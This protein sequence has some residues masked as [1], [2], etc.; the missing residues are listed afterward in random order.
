MTAVC[1]VSTFGGCRLFGTTLNMDELPKVLKRVNVLDDSRPY[2]APYNTRHLETPNATRYQRLYWP[3]RATAVTT[4]FSPEEAP[5]ACEEPSCPWKFETADEMKDHYLRH[6]RPD[7]D[8][9]NA[10]AVALGR[11]RAARDKLPRHKCAHTIRGIFNKLAPAVQERVKAQ[12]GALVKLCF[13]MTKAEWDGSKEAEAALQ[14]IAAAERKLPW[15][16]CAKKVKQIVDGLSDHARGVVE[17]ER[18]DLVRRAYIVCRDD[19]D[20]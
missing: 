18:S 6:H 2:T 15:M 20:T 11:I 16:K 3:S 10:A 8:A 12:E 13:R 4:F 19:G 7:W 1:D 14:R 9:D 5:F 17:Q